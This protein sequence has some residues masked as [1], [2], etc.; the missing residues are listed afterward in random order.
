MVPG[1][2]GDPEAIEVA[3]GLLEVRAVEGERECSL[4]SAGSAGRGATLARAE[5][6]DADGRQRTSGLAVGRTSA[7]D[8]GRRASE[9][10]TGAVEAHVTPRARPIAR[11]S[12][13]GTAIGSLRRRMAQRSST[14]R[15]WRRACA[16]R[17][18]QDVA[19]F[20]AE[21]GRPPGLATILVGEDPGSAIYVASKQKATAEVGMRGFD[22]RLPADA[23]REQVVDLI[24]QLNADPGRQRDPLPAAG[25]RPP[26]RRRA[27]RAHR[28]R[29]GRRRPHAGQRRPARARARRGCGRARRRA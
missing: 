5:Q 19:A 18:A 3:L 8:S 24:E 10:S 6:G 29:Q 2:I 26:R 22:H 15:P 23:T 20:T 16:P 4:G 14:A 1:L 28:P 11:V 17:S 21:H 13:D 7:A 27:D 12:L 25:P 9:A